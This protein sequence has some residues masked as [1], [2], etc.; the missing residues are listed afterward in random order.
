FFFPSSLL[1]FQ[2]VNRKA[3]S[4]SSLS[5]TSA[6]GHLLLHLGLLLSHF[7]L[8]FFFPFSF[9]CFLRSILLLLA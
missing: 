2:L 8:S 4:S 1:L 3:L 9:S 7:S 5:L 6:N